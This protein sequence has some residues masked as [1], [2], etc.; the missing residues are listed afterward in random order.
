MLP[1]IYSTTAAAPLLHAALRK[2]ALTPRARLAVGYRI[3]EAELR[4]DTNSV[5]R[6]QVRGLRPLGNALYLDRLL[7]GGIVGEAL[8][9]ANQRIFVEQYL[10]R[11]QAIDVVV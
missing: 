4:R 7:A 2:V 11:G 3:A 1:A 9:L 8:P 5:P 6:V 10:P